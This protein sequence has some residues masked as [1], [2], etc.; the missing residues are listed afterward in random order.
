MRKCLSVLVASAALLTVSAGNPLGFREYQQKFTLTFPTEQ[1]AQN[2][3]L[4]A[5][6]LPADYKV[7]F[8]SRWDD[9]APAHLKTHE[10]ML[11]HNIKGTFFLGTVHWVLKNHPDYLSELQ[12]G[13]C[14]I[15]LHTLTHPQLPGQNPNEQFREYMLNRIQLETR[16][17]TPINAQVL[18][19]CGWWSPD[20][21]VPQSIGWAMRATGVISSPDVLYPNR[22]NELGYPPKSFAQ[23][24]F[25]NP[26]DRNPDLDRLE[27]Q[28]ASALSNRKALAAQPSLSMS[29]HSWHTPKGLVNLDKAYARVANNPDWWYCNQNEYG[30]YRYEAQ[31]TSVTK[32]VNGRSAEFT[33]ARVQPFELGANVPLWFSVGNAKPSAAS[34]AKLHGGSVELPHDKS[35]TL[36]SVFGYAGADGRSKEIPFASLVLRHPFEKSWTAELNTLDGKPVEQLAFT[37]RFPA[38]YDRETVRK[39]VGTTSGVTV[40]ANLNAKKT[41]LYYRYG[42]PYYAVQA[43]FVRDGK[44]Y[45]LYADLQEKEE[46]N[47]PLTMNDVVQYFVSPESPDLAK[48]SAPSV[49]PSDLGLAPV[50]LK[51]RDNVGTGIIYPDRMS[52]NNWKEGADYLAVVDFKPLKAGKLTLQSTAGDSWQKSEVWMNGRKVAFKDR[53]AELDP[54]DGVNRIVLKAP[55]NRMHPLFLNGEREQCVEFLPRK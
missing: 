21:K 14:S 33:V 47:L 29:M 31:N 32:K 52:K 4:T 22:E 9:S 34:G 19:F 8:S 55:Q 41:E 36:P 37:F 1:D 27:K 13:G 42:R 48:L 17:Q 25:L 54:V 5:K 7:A 30:A 49:K 18:P 35:Q 43:D 39:D 12:Q 23:S 28:L 38:Q 15:G 26:G 10:I 53:K 44:R 50:A 2:A 16:A 11:K 46:A 24:R 3:V 40:T 20:P 45:R 6:P 51:K